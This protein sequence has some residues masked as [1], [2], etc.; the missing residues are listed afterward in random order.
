M[1][2]ARCALKKKVVLLSRL[3]DIRDVISHPSLCIRCV[4]VCDQMLCTLHRIVLPREVPSEIQGT[5][6]TE[7]EA[8]E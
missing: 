5:G 4:S 1:E 3:R 2:S 6:T 7:K 8:T